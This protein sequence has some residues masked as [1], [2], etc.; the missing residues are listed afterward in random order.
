MI[1]LKKI[2]EKL[3]LSEFLDDDNENQYRWE[4]AAEQVEGNEQDWYFVFLY[5]VFFID[6]ASR[7]ILSNYF[8]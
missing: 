6:Y 4:K 5:Q 3:V 7:I 1:T 2:F 8:L